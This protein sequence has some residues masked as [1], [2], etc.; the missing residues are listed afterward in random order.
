MNGINSFA[1]GD[2]GCN[3]RGYPNLVS[4]SGKYSTWAKEKAVATSI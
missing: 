3:K 4:T 2:F 1:E